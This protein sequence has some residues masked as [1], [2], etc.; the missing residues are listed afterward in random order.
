MKFRGG[1]VEGLSK[2]P[3]SGRVWDRFI[4]PR[5]VRFVTLDGS[6][7]SSSSGRYISLLDTESLLLDGLAG[8]ELSKSIVVDVTTF[9]RVDSFSVSVA[10]T[11]LEPGLVTLAKEVI[12]RWFSTGFD[13]VG[14]PTFGA[15][16]ARVD[17]VLVSNRTGLVAARFGLSA[18]ALQSSNVSGTPTCTNV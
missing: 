17:R 4:G 6:S 14:L 9:V 3:V 5:L 8:E 15:G 13:L 1:G 18:P 16:T 10:G 12:S 2:L 11:F 7:S